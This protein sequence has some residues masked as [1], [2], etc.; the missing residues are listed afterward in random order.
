MRLAQMS[1]M[2]SVIS[3]EMDVMVGLFQCLMLTTTKSSNNIQ[4]A[5]L[6]EGL[7]ITDY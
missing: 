5:K 7:R 4:L 6:L 3:L 1:K 2:R